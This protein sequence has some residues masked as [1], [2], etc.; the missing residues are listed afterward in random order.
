[1]PKLTVVCFDSLFCL[2]KYHVISVVWV[3]AGGGHSRMLL[4]M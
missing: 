4:L 3:F 1:M 2:H